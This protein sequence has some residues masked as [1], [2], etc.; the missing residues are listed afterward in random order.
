MQPTCTYED[1]H[2]CDNKQ[3]CLI[4]SRQMITVIIVT[5]ISANKNTVMLLQFVEFVL[6]IYALTFVILLVNSVLK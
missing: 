5:S 1:L 4:V 6:L 3:Y 2:T